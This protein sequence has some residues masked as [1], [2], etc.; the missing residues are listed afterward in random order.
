LVPASIRSL[1]AH[2][3][4]GDPT[5]WRAGLRVLELAYGRVADQP[6]EE[7]VIEDVAGIAAM[8][9]EARR[10]LLARLV[11]A[12]PDLAAQLGIEPPEL[13]SVASACDACGAARTFREVFGRHAASARPRFGVDGLRGSR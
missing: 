3:A 2:L 8:T 13:R 11:K 7:P 6:A 1:E 9:P 5:A 4:N 12:N 10:A